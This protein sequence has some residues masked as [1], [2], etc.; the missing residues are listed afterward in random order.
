VSD[1][2][3]TTEK[4]K[5]RD[6]KLWPRNPRQIRKVEAER[7]NQSLAEFG[8]V[9]TIAIGP[10]N[11]VYNGHQRIK[12][13]TQ[14]YGPD[15]E[16]EVRVASR[17]LTEKEREKL[18]VFLHRGAVGEWDF[19]I[20]ANEFDL[21]DL[22]QWG[23]EE[24]DLELD[25]WHEDDGLAGIPEGQQVFDD[26]Q[27]LDAAFEYFRATG[28]PYR[29]LPV[30]VSMQEIN[31]LAATPTEKL[32]ATITAYHVADTYH[33]HRFHA[34][35]AGMKS[36]VEAF[37]DDKLL[38]RALK[39]E[40]QYGGSIST[41]PI[42]KLSIVSGT[43][44]CSNFRP[45]VACLMYRKFAKRG[46]TVLD[47]STGYGGRLVGFMASGIAG[48][49]IGIDPNT[50]THEGNLRLAAD[51]GFSDNVE[52]YNLPAEDVDPDLLAGRCD[53]AFTSPPYFTKEHYSSDDTQSWVRYKTGDAWRNGFL[54]PFFRLQFA[55]LK[56]GAVS[57]VNIA[58]VRIQGEVYKLEHWAFEAA[59]S[60]GFEFVSRDEY[61]LTRR[62]GQE[63][64]EVSI[65]PVLV[66]RK[67]TV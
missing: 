67:P 29:D 8:Q 26:E 51:L 46:D 36:P 1:I 22:L 20:L 14:K 54:V 49:Y 9:E 50:P 5:L 37:E 13:W 55:A 53:F 3:W 47:C 56:P 33:P 48:R 4:R 32:P 25:L 42:G 61:T 64:D 18:T 21:G 17:A 65:E 31:K 62:F 38:R 12:V 19:D 44:A 40:L 10:N 43:Q 6:L 52:L 27:I 28:F 58:D 2:C 15:Y 16:V 7:L 45:G 11:E 66:F 59:R 23:F 24:R 34:L 39:H 63:E 30:F 35:A 41:H 60:V 57:A